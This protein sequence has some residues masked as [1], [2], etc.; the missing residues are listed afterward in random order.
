M[1]TQPWVIVEPP[2]E[3]GLRAVTIHEKTVGYAWSLRGMRKILKRLGYPEGMDL[4]DQ[5]SICW[6]GGGSGTWPDRP[7]RRR[8]TITLMMVGLLGCMALLI[9]VGIPDAFGALTFAQR[10]T[11]CL[12][13]LS[14]VI[15]GVAA[16]AAIDYWG[17]RRLRFSGALVSLGVIIAISTN[18]LFLFMWLQEREYVPYV[19]AFLLIG[20]WSLWALYVIIRYKPWTGIPHPKRFAAGVFATALIATVNFAYSAMYQPSSVPTLVE[21]KVEFGKSQPDPYLPFVH[22]PVKFHVKNVGAVGAYFINSDYSIN[23]RSAEYSSVTTKKM[24]DWKE[25]AEAGEDYDIYARHPEFVTIKTGQ[26]WEP[27]YWLDAGEQAH[28]EY[29]VELPQNTSYDMIEAVLS[30]DLMRRDRGKI[31]YDEFSTAHFSWDKEDRYYCGSKDCG[32]Y[33]LYR[34]LVKHNNNVVNVTRKP[35]YVA[36]L[37]SWDSTDYFVSSYNFGKKEDFDEEETSRERD[38]YGLMSLTTNAV[39]PVAA[40]LKP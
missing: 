32:E 22:L 9:D 28:W 37:W 1:R 40:L 39:V 25:I 31:D 34:G 18:G 30:V 15:Q 2:D 4:E 16:F 13:I 33:I 5:T 7:W 8:T 24:K 14:G 36:A 35:R 19:R 20:S 21:M 12:F 23:E 3:R 38:R 11:G 17:I 27:G 6:R 29:V 26:P 10:I